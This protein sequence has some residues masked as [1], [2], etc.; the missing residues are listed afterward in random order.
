MPNRSPRP[1]HVRRLVAL[2]VLLAAPAALAQSPSKYPAANQPLEGPQA[3]LEAVARGYRERSVATVMAQ[4]TAD[5]RFHSMG[6]GDTLLR[7]VDGFARA[8]EER[9]L[10]NMFEGVT[11]DGK[12]VRPPVDSVGMTMDGFT[13]GVDPEHPDSTAQYRV[14]TVARFELGFRMDDSTLGLGAPSRNVFHLVRGDVARLLPDQP[15]DAGHWYIRR[16]LEDVNGVLEALRERQGDCG[17][18]EAPRPGAATGGA[19]A[20]GILPLGNPACASLKLTCALPEAGAARLEVYDVSGRR[21]NR[22]EI[23]AARP[24][25]IDVEAGAGAKLLPGPYWVR[26]TQGAHRPVTRMVMVAR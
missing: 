18:P 13:E 17:E 5:Y 4:Y 2:V 24:G 19:I 8:D 10:R 20:L 7:F 6:E 11:R 21:V 23:S 12:V 15:A 3:A 22:R 9:S 16:W 1:A 14:V 25:R 26:L